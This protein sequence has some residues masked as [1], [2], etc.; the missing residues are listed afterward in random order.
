MSDDLVQ[1]L[2]ESLTPEQKQQ[3]VEGLLGGVANEKPAEKPSESPAE[4]P[5]QSRQPAI[6]VNED[7]T[8]TRSDEPSNRKAPVRAKKNRWRDDGTDRDPDFDPEKFEK[9]GRVQRSRPEPTKAEVT[10][11]I[12]GKRFKINSSLVYGENMRCN[13]CTGR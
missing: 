11:H 7:F 2:L 8:V 3:L 5:K 10:C 9:M 4:K 13:R 6:V 1:T 12:C